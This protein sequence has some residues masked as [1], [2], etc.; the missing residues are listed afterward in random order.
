[1]QAAPAASLVVPEA[2]FL[3]ELLIVPLDP[4]AQLGP[5]NQILKA[6]RLW[7]CGQPVF[8]RLGLVL[9]PLDQQP[10][11]GRLFGLGHRTDAQTGKAGGEGF[12]V[13]APGDPLSDRGRLAKCQRLGGDLLR[14]PLR[15]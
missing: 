2:K 5:I 6:N 11:L 14:P 4:P 7:Q 10:L 8:G 1:M 3:L 13:L 12:T 9:R 15:T